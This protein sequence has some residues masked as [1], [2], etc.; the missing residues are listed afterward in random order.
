MTSLKLLVYA[1]ISEQSALLA[2]FGPH[3]VWQQA[4][5][6]FLGHLIS[7][8]LFSVLLSA[9]F[10]KRFVARRY[11]LVGL[12]FCFNFFV[13]VLGA[14]GTLLVLFYF[15]KYLSREGRAE[16]F[17][18]PMP[19]FLVESAEMAPG[20]G[21][22]GAWSRLKSEG[23][24]REQRLKALMAVGGG[25]GE[26]VSRFLQKATGDSDDEIRLLAF[27]LHERQEQKI[28]LSISAALEELKQTEIPSAKASLCRNLA[29]SYWE[30]VYC[31]LAQDELRDFFVEQ[32]AKYAEQAQQYGGT[33]PVL[34]T[35]VARIHL[36]K[37]EYLQAEESV[38]KALAEGADPIRV[39]PYQAELAFYRRDY[40]AIKYLLQQD[41]T[42]RF[43]PGIGP[44]AQF[45]G[46]R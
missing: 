46:A 18:V 19:P 42:L 24:P 13:P 12:F 41:A 25:S 33:D 8:A 23:L 32:A 9:I 21:E 10:P 11:G 28:Q 38:Q 4:L 31:A 29:F 17:N 7:S 45:W 15:R 37:R 40:S 36:Q 22:G 43:K 14:I 20:M 34:T 44:V 39:V 27:N 35:L 2:I 6:F 5:L 30:M 3:P 26:N 1:L 16:F